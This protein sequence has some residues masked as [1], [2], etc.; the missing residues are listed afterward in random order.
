M[1][2]DDRAAIESICRRYGDRPEALI[3]ILHDVQAQAGCVSDE[4]VQVIA[5][6][7]NLSRADVHGVRSYYSDFTTEKDGRCVV[8][9][10]RAE[11]CKA[12]GAD[13]LADAV[14]TRLGVKTGETAADGSVSVKTVF[15]LG[16]CALGPAAMIGD[17]LIGRATPD[18]IEAKLAEI[19]DG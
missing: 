1:A 4:A 18:R 12:V 8:R 15:C 3:E 11:A 19:A 6:R 7:L 5:D 17:Q 2:Q 10:C 9:L 13:M 16:D 14:E